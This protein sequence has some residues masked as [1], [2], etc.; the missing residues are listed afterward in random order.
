MSDAMVTP[1]MFTAFRRYAY[2][3][4]AIPI[5]LLMPADATPLA[6]QARHARYA[7]YTQRVAMPLLRYVRVTDYD[8]NI[9]VR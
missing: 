4:H 6:R 2:G 8:D 1:N 9:S 7:L 5:E 3:R